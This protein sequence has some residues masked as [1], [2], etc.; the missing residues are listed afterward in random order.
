MYRYR[1]EPWK[2]KVKNTN[3]DPA[4]RGRKQE[5]GTKY[6]V[7][8]KKLKMELRYDPDSVSGNASEEAQ[9]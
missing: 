3:K 8:L 1:C 6:G 4:L 2:Y 5:T 9:N 7:F